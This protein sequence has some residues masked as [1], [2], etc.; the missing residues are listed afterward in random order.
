MVPSIQRLRKQAKPNSADDGLFAT[1]PDHWRTDLEDRRTG[2]EPSAGGK[3]AFDFHGQSDPL[4][5]SALIR[6]IAE[7]VEAQ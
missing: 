6:S 3:R 5:L 1:G 4:P 2:F 7:H